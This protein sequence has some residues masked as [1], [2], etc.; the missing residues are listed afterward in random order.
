[1]QWS[2]GGLEEK[3]GGQQEKAREDKF[4]WWWSLCESFR[5]GWWR[6]MSPNVSTMSQ[7]GP[8]LMHCYYFTAVINAHWLLLLQLKMCNAPVTLEYRML[9]WAGPETWNRGGSHFLRDTYH[10]GHG[11][12]KKRGGSTWTVEEL[13]FGREQEVL[14]K[15]TFQ[16]V[17]RWL[18]RCAWVLTVGKVLLWMYYSLWVCCQNS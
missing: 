3:T 5:G 16:C 10:N 9:S 6:F 2:L 7:H 17:V 14:V 12:L 15:G 4:W 11:G 13:G 18:W 8:P 1:M